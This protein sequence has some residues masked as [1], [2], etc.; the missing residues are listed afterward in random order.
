MIMYGNS[1]TS[2]ADPLSKV[3]VE[4]IV[5]AIKS[6][7]PEIETQIN[8]LRIV[9]EID[10]KMYS[11]LKRKLPYIVCGIFNPAF[12]KKEN[13]A[14]IEY[15]IVDIDHI[16][17]K[18]LDIAQL[19]HTLQNDQRV[20]TAFVSP[21]GDGMKLMFRL[22][23]K[24]YDPNIFSVFY[25]EFARQF[26]TQYR[27]NQVVDT[28][29]SDV[30]RACFI[31]IDPDIYYQPNATPVDVSAYNIDINNTI[32]LFDTIHSQR[33]E[34]K[35]LKKEQ[36]KQHSAEAQNLPDDIVAQIRQ[37]L[38]PTK[39]KQTAD[40]N[41]YVPGLLQEISQP[42]ATYLADFDISVTEIIKIQYGLKFRMAVGLRQ[43][44]INIFHGKKGFSVV[45]SPRQGTDNEL[46]ELT[47]QVIT[48]FIYDYPNLASQHQHK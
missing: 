2:V 26:S 15:F 33:Q 21:S 20:L 32:S 46:N 16:S 38:N 8:R 6:P 7:K 40:K 36:Q 18:N 24:C 34:E 4:Y 27:L 39:T 19:R 3:P 12:R 43:A 23:E 25:K 35:A 37:R 14:Y 42:L 22:S 9:R 31:S 10:N 44:E 11:Q 5:Q 47:Q 13:L 29:T 28:A 48:Q 41:V 30:S 17:D 45:I 1:I